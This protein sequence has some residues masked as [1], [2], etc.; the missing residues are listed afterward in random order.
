M[1][2]S[3]ILRNEILNKV[4]EYYRL[5]HAKSGEN[6]IP[7]KSS[8]SYGGRIFDEKEIKAAVSSS[9]DFWLTLGREG[10]A[11]E[12]E[13][14][15]FLDIR[16]VSLVNSGSSANLLAF[17]ALTSPKLE[18]HISPGDEVITVA[19]GFPTT[20]NPIIQYG[21]VPVFVDI[22]IPSFNIDCAQLEAAVSSRTR[23]VM[24]AHTLGNPFDIGRVKAFCDKHKLW[25]IEDNCDALG[26]KY[27]NKFTGTFGDIG[28]SSFYPPH[29]ITM[30]EGGAVYT[31]SNK[32]KYIVESF[33]DWG[34]DCYCASG[35]DNTCKKRFTQQF[36][37]LP[38]GYDHKYVYSHI[39]YNMKPTDIQ[40]AIG[41]EQLRKLP[42]FIEARKHNWIFLRN[43][44]A[45]LENKWYFMEASP[46]SD[47]S[48]FGFL[49]VMKNPD[50][51]HLT[52]LCRNLE[53]KKI[54]HRRLFA[55]NLLWHPAYENIKSRTVNKLINT[56]KVALGGLFLGV[57]P[58]L[59][60]AMLQHMAD[61]LKK[62]SLN[63]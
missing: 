11:F 24:L 63:I 8:I 42:S 7:G 55:G 30:G 37:K 15:A 39:G 14:A 34:R 38:L 13:L 1:T 62:E 46:E 23:A 50:H 41:R 9:L 36:G 35:Q 51:E 40:A 26:S 3:E 2:N 58:G 47:P 49:M 52:E 44:L 27:K 28:T 19:A 45:D 53:A 6:F 5:V 16:H 61:S 43:A 32:L 56:E 31:N 12:K 59:S 60:E 29:H 18:N 57:Y 20:V 4:T 54:G 22:D 25:L 48:W 33:R 17:A 21:C 10:E